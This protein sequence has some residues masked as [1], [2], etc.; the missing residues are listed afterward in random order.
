VN[1]IADQPACRVNA[2]A[3]GHAGKHHKQ[4]SA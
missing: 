2:K 1:L 3:K 4:M